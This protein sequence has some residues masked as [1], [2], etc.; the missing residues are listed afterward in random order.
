MDC[1]LF[2]NVIFL[3]CQVGRLSSSF[4]VSF[5]FLTTR[6]LLF[7]FRLEPLEEDFFSLNMSICVPCLEKC[8]SLLGRSAAGALT[9]NDRSVKWL[10]IW[11]YSST[12]FRALQTLD[13]IYIVTTYTLLSV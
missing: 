5:L 3:V 7:N 4:V 1:T 8:H 13:Y 10:F 11:I 12:L 6:S 2:W 9:S